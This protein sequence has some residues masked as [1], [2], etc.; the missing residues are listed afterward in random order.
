MKVALYGRALTEA[1]IP[2][3][4]KE[5]SVQVLKQGDA[6]QEDVDVLVT[7]GGDG[8]FLDA[9][10]IVKDTN[11]PIA[12]INFGRLGFLAGNRPQS[13]DEWWDMLK[14]K[15]YTTVKHTVLS[16]HIEDMPMSVFPYAVNEVSVQREGPAML[17][18]D[19]C[20]DNQPL[21]TY[22]GDGLIVATPTGSTAY[23]LS[24]GGPIVFPKSDVILLSSIAPH[25]L[26][27]RPI[28]LPSDAALHVKV[29]SR[30]GKAVLTVDNRSQTIPSGTSFEVRKAS[31]ALN[32]LV[33]PGNDFITTL[34]DKFMW[35]FDKRNG[36]DK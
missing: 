14:Q 32:S 13:V 23:S 12:G 34:R 3:E 30:N 26:N 27:V 7:L 25:N 4:D 16:V 17:E 15:Q 8:T 10:E 36:S 31:F 35:G 5:L 29:L 24:V 21:S 11:I 33:F 20:V 18:M 9:L 28:V 6:L 1:W 19:V 22:R 2:K